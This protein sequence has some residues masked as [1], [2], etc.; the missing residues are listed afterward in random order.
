MEYAHCHGQK[1]STVVVL[2]LLCKNTLDM[3]SLNGICSLLAQLLPGSS[4]L[5]MTGEEANHVAF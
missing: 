2:L 3:C 4:I 5:W 1:G